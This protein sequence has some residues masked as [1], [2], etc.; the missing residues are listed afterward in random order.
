MIVSFEFFEWFVTALIFVVSVVWLGV[1][2]V[3]LRRALRDV[4]APNRHDRIFGSI[5]GLAVATV[6]VVGVLLYHLG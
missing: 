1:D 5:I 6:G 4:G 3:R 2:T